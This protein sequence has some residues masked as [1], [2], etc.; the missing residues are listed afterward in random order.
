MSN[1]NTAASSPSIAI[2]GLAGSGKTVLTVVLAKRLGKD[3]S[4]GIL[5]EPNDPPTHKFVETCWDRLQ[6][7]QWPESTAQGELNELNWTLRTGSGTECQVRLADLPGQDLQRLFEYGEINRLESLEATD[8]R[9]VGEYCRDACIVI[10]LVNL[11]DFMG[12]SDTERR[13]GN[14]G[15]IKAVVDYYLKPNRRVFIAINQADLYEHAEKEAG[16]W[17][18]LL[19][20]EAFWIYQFV[21]RGCDWDYVSAV[22]DTEPD[23]RVSEFSDERIPRRIPKRGFRSVNLRERLAGWLGA[24]AEQF[25]EEERNKAWQ[26]DTGDEAN[27]GATSSDSWWN[28]LSGKWG[29]VHWIAVLVV[30]VAIVLGVS[31]WLD[32]PGGPPEPQEP[33]KAGPLAVQIERRTYKKPDLFDDCIYGVL[34]VRNDGGDGLISVT[35]IVRQQGRE[36]ERQTKTAYLFA[37][38]KCIFD[39]NLCKIY[40]VKEKYEVLYALSPQ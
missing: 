28:Y 7:G 4:T 10:V 5:L 33:G 21:Q 31:Y 12:E 16:G 23:D 35:A 27:Y 20:R 6:N 30:G 1:E 34:A 13:A 37:G 22:W 29:D 32:P 19:K 39:F 38:E 18:Q 26:N 40:S 15:A 9:A 8:L 11:K 2:V 17:E 36:I 25:V 24:Q 3:N 14:E